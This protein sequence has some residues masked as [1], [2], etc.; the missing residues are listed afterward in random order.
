MEIGRAKNFVQTPDVKVEKPELKEEQP[1]ESKKDFGDRQKADSFEQGKTGSDEFFKNASTRAA[2]P[3][4]KADQATS[5]LLSKQVTQARLGDG[6]KQTSSQ[7]EQNGRTDMNSKEKELAAATQP[8]LPE[9]KG[10]KTGG[11]DDQR[12]NKD[13]KDYVAKHGSGTI[14]GSVGAAAAGEYGEKVKDAMSG[15]QEN[16]QSGASDARDRLSEKMAAQ[17]GYA[18][19]ADDARKALNDQIR[20]AVTQDGGAAAG[21]GYGQNMVS[22]DL[23]Y[24]ANDGGPLDHI[25]TYR[26]EET[27]KDVTET[28][29]TKFGK[30]SIET[31]LVID[32]QK[33]GETSREMYKLSEKKNSDGSTTQTMYEAKKNKDGNSVWVLIYDGSSQQNGTSQTPSAKDTTQDEY[34][35]GQSEKMH[36]LMKKL[37]SRFGIDP[38]ALPKSHHSPGPNSGNIDGKEQIDKGALETNVFVQAGGIGGMVGQSRGSDS[39]GGSFHP[40]ETGTADGTEYSGK[41]IKEDEADVDIT[42]GDDTLKQ[43]ASSTKSNEE[44]EKKFSYAKRTRS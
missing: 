32:R 43:N 30:D 17:K 14:G 22:E 8:D 34:G 6:H 35:K 11:S 5:D 2:E 37:G 23:T 12:Q 38:Y 36:N 20:H 4:K 18:H 7:S 15:M 21:R 3:E 13:L 16:S 39:D 44:E 9:R 29:R 19:T 1:A 27:G 31:I 24:W 10:P 33:N 28:T 40:P 41:T 26:D 42:V 25:T